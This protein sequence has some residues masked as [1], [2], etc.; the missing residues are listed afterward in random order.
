MG[1]A[2]REIQLTLRAVIFHSHLLF[3]LAV[4]RYDANN[5]GDYYTRG[6]FQF[7]VEIARRPMDD[8]Y[9]QRTEYISRLIG[10]T[11]NSRD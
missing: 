2:A 4:Q 10:L 7:H 9:V 6:Q 8:I 11:L 1:P 3:S 5:N